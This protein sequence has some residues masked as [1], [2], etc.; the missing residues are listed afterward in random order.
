MS[1]PTIVPSSLRD[2]PALIEKLLPMQKVSAEACK[3]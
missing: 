1:N 2:A 3:E